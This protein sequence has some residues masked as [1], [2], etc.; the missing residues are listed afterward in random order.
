MRT[1]SGI[2]SA[3]HQALHDFGVVLLHLRWT[4]LFTGIRLIVACSE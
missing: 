4:V 2:E 1:L 3:F